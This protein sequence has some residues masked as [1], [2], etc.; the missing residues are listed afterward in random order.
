MK[1]R[2][3]AHACLA[4]LLLAF[5]CDVDPSESEFDDPGHTHREDETSTSV[6]VVTANLAH[7][8]WCEMLARNG[9]VDEDSCNVEQT[10]LNPPHGVAQ[11]LAWWQVEYLETLQGPGPTIFNTQE[12]TVRDSRTVGGLWPAVLALSLGGNEF[13]P[14]FADYEACY[15]AIYTPHDPVDDPSG[16]CQATPPG[17]SRSWGNAITTNLAVEEYRAWNLDHECDADRVERRAHAARM[18][19]GDVDVWSVNVHLEY[20]KGGDF[21][22][23]ACNLENLFDKLDTL[24]DDDVVVV[25]GDFN[26][27]PDALPD[28]SDC[29]GAIHP[30]RFFEMAHGFAGRQFLRLESAGV[31]H[32]FLRDPHYELS[33]EDTRILDPLYQVGEETYEMSDHDI[34]ETEL[35][36]GGP[37]MSP[38]FLPLYVTLN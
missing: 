22:V 27:R 31:D 1:T 35:D 10:R 29:P 3:R 12:A 2:R 8:S 19:V 17:N 25:S 21:S 9:F 24:P 37:G 11:L 33:G 23:N 26:I 6:R 18:R 30:A 13:D 32:V 4:T 5:A 16:E 14:A 7:V 34:L 20:C 15:D 28:S 36:V 38:A